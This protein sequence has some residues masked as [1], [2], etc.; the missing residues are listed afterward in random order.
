MSFLPDPGQKPFK[1]SDGIAAIKRA[2]LGMKIALA[3]LA[4]ATACVGW[5]LLITYRSAIRSASVSPTAELSTP[6]NDHG[7][8]LYITAK[9]SEMIGTSGPV[10]F[11]LTVALTGIWFYMSGF[12]KYLISMLRKNKA[13]A[14]PPVLK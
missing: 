2:P 14:V 10:S 8:T 3:V 1:A 9:Q 4:I 7:R 5:T 13:D 11:W 6:I 12:L